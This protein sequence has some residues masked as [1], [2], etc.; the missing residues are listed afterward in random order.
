MTVRTATYAPRP[1]ART[2]VIDGEY[3]VVEPD[4]P[5]L[6]PGDLDRKQD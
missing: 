2:D 4:A 6:Q 1:A 3:S 5:K